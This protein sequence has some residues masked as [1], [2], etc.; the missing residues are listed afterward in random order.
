MPPMRLEFFWTID[1][2]LNSENEWVK[3][4]DIQNIDE[5][6]QT[7]NLKRIEKTKTFFVEGFLTH[8]KNH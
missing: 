4:I 7:Y 5:S 2:L 6:V 3:V 1:S 8:N